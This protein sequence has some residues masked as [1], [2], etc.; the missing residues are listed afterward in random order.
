MVNKIDTEGEVE[1]TLNSLEGL[2]RT[3]APPFIMTRIQQSIVN[4]Q[5]QNR[6]YG[7]IGRLAMVMTLLAMV[8]SAYFLQTR[9]RAQPETETA[10]A[11]VA[12][13]YALQYNATDF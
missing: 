4:R 6:Q 5:E 8:N 3:A 9:N 2:Q 7:K 13:E 11:A 10:A 1:R 12:A